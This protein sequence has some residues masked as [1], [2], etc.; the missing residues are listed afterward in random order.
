[1]MKKSL[2]VVV[3]CLLTLSFIML[4]NKETAYG[5]R[6]T[7][8]ASE[9]VSYMNSLVGATNNYKGYCLLFVSKCWEAMGF[10]GSY[11]WGNATNFTNKNLVSTSRDNIPVGADVFF[12]SGNGDGHIGIYIGNGYFVHADSN[13]VY[14]KSNLSEK[15]Y[16]NRYIGWGWHP[17]VTVIS[18]WSTTGLT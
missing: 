18:V 17:Y 10:P 9:V 2:I 7:I 14:E 4:S 1:M 5:A 8:T 13:D 15:E 11:N 3:I 12:T 6:E 16:S